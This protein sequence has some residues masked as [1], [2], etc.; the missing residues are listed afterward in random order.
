M[1]EPYG[2]DVGAEDVLA[3]ITGVPADNPSDDS[4]FIVF[5]G[6]SAAGD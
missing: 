5:K 3:E 4:V 2:P 1:L 6:G